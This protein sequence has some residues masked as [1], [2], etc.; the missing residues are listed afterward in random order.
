MLCVELAN[1]RLEI[2][3]FAQSGIQL[4]D[5]DF[6]FGAQM[7][8]CLDPIKQLPPQLLLNCFRERRGF[9]DRDFQ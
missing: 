9:A 6:N 1:E 2:K 4:A 8:Q 7:L 5:A 3:L